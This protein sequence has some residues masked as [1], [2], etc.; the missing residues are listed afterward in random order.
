MTF[1]NELRDLR[2][3]NFVMIKNISPMFKYILNLIININ[4]DF[5]KLVAMVNP[6]R[7]R[8]IPKMTPINN[9]PNL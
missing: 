4:N 1:S 5:R 2:I 7:F 8:K 3:R 6:L 9:S